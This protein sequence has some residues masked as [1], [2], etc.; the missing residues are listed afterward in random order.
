MRL[1]INEA[2]SAVDRPWNRTFL[3]FTF[4]CYTAN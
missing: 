4:S 2:K 1:K 3:G